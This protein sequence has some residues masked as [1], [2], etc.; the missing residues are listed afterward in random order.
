M[1]YK[2]QSKPTTDS[3]P[4]WGFT[5]DHFCFRRVG[6]ATDSFRLFASCITPCNTSA[7]PSALTNFN[8]MTSTLW[9]SLFFFRVRTP[10]STLAFFPPSLTKE[11]KKKK[12]LVCEFLLVLRPWLILAAVLWK[13][14]KSAQSWKDVT[15]RRRQSTFSARRQYAHADTQ[16]NTQ[17][18]TR[19]NQYT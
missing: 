7:Q 18:R 14:H 9:G 2:C 10:K 3:W 4:I 6:S 19:P 11:K 5:L 15:E 13:S 12:K 1:T 17:S 8:W 16:S